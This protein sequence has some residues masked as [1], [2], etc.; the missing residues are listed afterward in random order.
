MKTKD[1]AI[2]VIKLPSKAKILV[3]VGDKV[4]NDQKLA[5]FSSHK[6]ETF[7]YSGPLSK[8]DET[9]R[10][11]LDNF[12]RGKQVNSGDMFCDLGIF[13]NKIF[14]PLT[15][16]CLGLDEFKNLR[17]EKIEE[18]KKE[19]LSPVEA[20]VSKIEEGKMVLEFK[21][22]E[23]SGTGLNQLKAWG[24]GEIK[25]VDDIKLLNFELDDNVLFT[26]NL[27]KTFLLK[28]QVIGVRAVVTPNE[29]VKEVD[30]NIPVLRLEKKVWED[31]MK[32]N[33]G[34]KRKML[35]NASKEKLLLVL[36]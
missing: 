25:I 15:G 26:E 31:F 5:I 19:I 22:K 9:K 8:M 17:I 16:L 35:V 24:N 30:I 33:L 10:Q 11:D 32:E 12:I 13:K 36:E 3:K 4:D 6:I 21:A 34:K 7:D 23:Y 1:K 27:D 29:D 28:A 2:W 18:D 20:K 14:F